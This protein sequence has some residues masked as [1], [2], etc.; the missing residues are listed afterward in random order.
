MNKKK[1]LPY[2]AVATM[3]AAP[4]SVSANEKVASNEP[5]TQTVLQSAP[6]TEKVNVGLLGAAGVFSI[7]FM[8]LFISKQ[9]EIID[10]FAD[11]SSYDNKMPASA[12]FASLLFIA[13]FACGITG[14]ADNETKKVSSHQVQHV[15]KQ[16]IK[17]RE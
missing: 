12:A 17:E 16:N 13:A 5:Q 11:V 1:L 8:I 10:Y 2:L 15:V 7:A 9:D 6:K 3:F 14:A 4:L